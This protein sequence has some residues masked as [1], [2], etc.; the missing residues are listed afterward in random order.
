MPLDLTTLSPYQLSAN[1]SFSKPFGYTIAEETVL[2]S[3]AGSDGLLI[4]EVENNAAADMTVTIEPGQT[5]PA[6]NS[7]GFSFTVYATGT[8]GVGNDPSKKILGPFSGENVLQGDGSILVTFEM[9]SGSPDGVA[10]FYR[11]PKHV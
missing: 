10:V 3:D 11:L 6:M 1:A 7:K 5:P 9:A 8:E 2:V 4:I